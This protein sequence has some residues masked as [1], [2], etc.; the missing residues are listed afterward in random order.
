MSNTAVEAVEDDHPARELIAAY[1]AELTQ[2]L[3]T[4]CRSMGAG[5]PDALGDALGL[6]LMGLFSAR[7]ASDGLAQANAA[8]DAA[9]ALMDSPALGVGVGAKA[10]R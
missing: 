8:V 3:R 4:L 7:L 10:K 2:R 1:R 6:L 5:Q 9:K